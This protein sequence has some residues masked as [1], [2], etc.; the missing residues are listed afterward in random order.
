M[1]SVCLSTGEIIIHRI[2]GVL[3]ILTVLPGI[4][5][6]FGVLPISLIFGIYLLINKR[7]HLAFD[8]FLVLIG[9]LICY[10]PIPFL[11]LG[12]AISNLKLFLLGS[13]WSEL[14]IKLF[15]IFNLNKILILGT[16]IALVILDIF[17]HLKNFSKLAKRELIFS[18]ILL[19]SIIILF[20]QPLF[21]PAVINKEGITSIGQGGSLIV[22]FKFDYSD[23]KASFNTQDNLWTYEIIPKNSSSQD[24]EII[25]I[26]GQKPTKPFLGFLDIYS[27]TEVIAPPF[28]SHIKVEEAEK[29]SDRVIVRAGETAI[30][31]IYS[32]EPIYQISLLDNNNCQYSLGFLTFGSEVQFFEERGYFSEKIDPNIKILLVNNFPPSPDLAKTTFESG[33]PIYPQEIGLPKG[34]KYGFR[35]IDLEGNVIIPFDERYGMIGVTKVGKGMEGSGFFNN[36]EK[37]LP[38]DTYK[39]E[40]IRVEGQEGVIVAYQNFTINSK[41]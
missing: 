33:E 22:S 14:F 32:K 3:I 38:P 41:D 9:I 31:K 27:K 12:P 23:G 18:L 7:Y 5:F 20:I 34:V 10:Y 30:L 24:V 2:L 21:R 15:L 8:I 29:M 36:K 19:A 39:I 40:L 25:K 4:H 28:G 11:F 17:I 37:A 35:V 1:K 16:A 6:G 26:S 13:S